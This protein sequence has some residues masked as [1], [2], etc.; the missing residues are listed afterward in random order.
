MEKYTRLGPAKVGDVFAE[1]NINIFPTEPVK[2][3]T[4]RRYGKSRARQSHSNY[5]RDLNFV[6]LKQVST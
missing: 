4:N 5:Q 1:S 6:S 3:Y 2:K